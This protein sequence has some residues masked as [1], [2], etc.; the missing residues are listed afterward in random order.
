MTD[1]EHWVGEWKHTKYFNRVI[2]EDIA[3]VSCLPSLNE[4]M[5]STRSESLIN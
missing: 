1:P 5:L 3:E 4:N 2:D